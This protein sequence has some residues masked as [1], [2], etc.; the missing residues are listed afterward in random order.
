MPQKGSEASSVTLLRIAMRRLPLRAANGSSLIA[1]N[2]ISGTRMLRQVKQPRNQFGTS[3]SGTG[4]TYGMI[5]ATLTLGST[6]CLP[7]TGI[8]SVAVCVTAGCGCNILFTESSL[9]SS[10]PADCSD[11]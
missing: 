8:N 9:A 3:S 10:T 11:Y 6:R 2:E 4:G 7:L 1:S 5:S